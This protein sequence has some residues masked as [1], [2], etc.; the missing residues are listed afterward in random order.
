MMQCMAKVFRLLFYSL[1]L[2]SDFINLLDN[3]EMSTGVA[4]HVTKEELQE[5]HLFLD[6]ILKTE[7]MKVSYHSLINVFTLLFSN[8]MFEH[9][10][11]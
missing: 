3:Y 11:I 5:N 2:F 1:C 4:E 9:V 6:A 7:V 8:V 10:E